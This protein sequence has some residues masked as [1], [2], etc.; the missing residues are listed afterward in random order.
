MKCG[1]WPYTTLMAPSCGAHHSRPSSSSLHAATSLAE[2]NDQGAVVEDV[3]THERTQL[4]A[5]SVV[6]AI[7]FRP[8]ASL[9][10]ELRSR[11][12]EV[13]EVGDGRQ[14]GNIM[15]AIWKAYEVAR[16]I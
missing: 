4:V 14:V 12:I 15:T 10:D 7:G 1:K 8:L 3:S 5:D 11:G 9:A 13:T 6:L 16:G 2:V